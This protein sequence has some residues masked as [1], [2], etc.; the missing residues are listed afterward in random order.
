MSYFIND[1]NLVKELYGFGFLMFVDGLFLGVMVLIRMFSL[2]L[3]M[4]FYVGILILFMGVLVY[5][6]NRKM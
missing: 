5:F 2:N 4:I 1:F 6:L 3:V